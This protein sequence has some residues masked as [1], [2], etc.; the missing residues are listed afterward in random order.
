MAYERELKRD[1]RRSPHPDG[2][3]NENEFFPDQ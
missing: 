1:H 3:M 2:Y